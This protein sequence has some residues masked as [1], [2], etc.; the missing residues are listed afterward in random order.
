MKYYLCVAIFVALSAAAYALTGTSPPV[1]L[2][3]TITPSNGTS[4]SDG[5][6]FMLGSYDGAHPTSSFPAGGWCR[7]IRCPETT[8]DN[9]YLLPGGF[10]GNPANNNGYPTSVE[11]GWHEGGCDRAH[12]G[13]NY[14][15]AAMGLPGGPCDALWTTE[16]NQAINYAR[17]GHVRMI[18]WLDEWADGYH[19]D[20][21]SPFCNPNTEPSCPLD[22]PATISNPSLFTNFWRHRLQLARSNFAAAAVPVPPMSFGIPTDPSEVQFWAYDDLVDLAGFDLYIYNDPSKTS[23]QQW[24]YF[25]GGQTLPCT[26]STLFGFLA[27]FA[28]QHNKPIFIGELGDC[29]LYGDGYEMTKIIEWM[30]ASNVVGANYWNGD[31]Y[32]SGNAGSDCTLSRFPARLQ[33]F[34][35]AFDVPFNPTGS[36]WSRGWANWGSDPLTGGGQLTGCPPGTDTVAGGCTS[37][38]PFY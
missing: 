27:N 32:I 22:A 13:S 1:D 2:T 9:S 8:L 14:T 10:G 37:S 21:G 34:Q 3:I 29:E 23:M 16:D 17:A 5:S 38:N 36:F 31:L 18:R 4:C 25:C 24:A 33:A 30:F 12:L 35:N 15:Y 7:Q 20:G 26:S 28:A 11:D 19:Q 6:C